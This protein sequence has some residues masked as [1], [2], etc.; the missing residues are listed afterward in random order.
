[1]GVGSITSH[2]LRKTLLVADS[3]P[4][5]TVNRQKLESRP[6]VATE[7]LPRRG[8]SLFLEVMRN[9]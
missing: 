9:C 6:G 8:L 1:M 7:E 4:L 3:E 5:S 2:N